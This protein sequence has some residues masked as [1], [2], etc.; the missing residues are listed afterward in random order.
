MIKQQSFSL[1]YN[2][3]AAKE[4]FNNYIY[5]FSYFLKKSSKFWEIAQ[6]QNLNFKTY[7]ANAVLI[8]IMRSDV[9]EK[10]RLQTVSYSV[11]DPNYF[12]IVCVRG[13][14]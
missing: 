1:D 10:L 5:I 9:L 3:V 14:N 7:V 12:A 11:P 13:S 6:S 2:N 4:C 8:I